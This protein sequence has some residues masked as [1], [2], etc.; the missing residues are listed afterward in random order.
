MVSSDTT[1][2][3]AGALPWWNKM[4]FPSLPRLFCEHYFLYPR[5]SALALQLE[6]VIPASNPKIFHTC[7]IIYYYMSIKKWA[8]G[9]SLYFTAQGRKSHYHP[10]VVMKSKYE[11]VFKRLHYLVK[12]G[13]TI[14]FLQASVLKRCLIKARTSFFSIMMFHVGMHQT[15]RH[16]FF[17]FLK[18]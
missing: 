2:V 13:M 1:A 18:L 9:K 12:S 8:E 7:I 15:K 10:C 11:R 4:P 17:S 3:S 16:C 6:L 14:T 5:L